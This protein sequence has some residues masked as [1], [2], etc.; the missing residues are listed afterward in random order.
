MIFRWFLQITKV[1]RAW[2]SYRN[3]SQVNEE[4]PAARNER[5]HC[6]NQPHE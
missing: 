1:R 3:G 6:E 2:L 4:Y 5:H